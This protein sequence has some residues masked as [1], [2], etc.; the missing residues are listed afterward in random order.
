GVYP[1]S[2]QA[3]ANKSQNAAAKATARRGRKRNRPTGRTGK[4]PAGIQ[5]IQ[6]GAGRAG[7]NGRIAAF[8]GKAG[9]CAERNKEAFGNRKRRER[10]A[11]RGLVQAAESLPKGNAALRDRAEQ[12]YP[13]GGAIPVYD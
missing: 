3:N 8:Q 7:S 4:T 5:K 12:T 1:G 9:E 10:A 6:V 2:G 13:H 11:K